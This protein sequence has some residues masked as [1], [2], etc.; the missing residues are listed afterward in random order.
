MTET[1]L[2]RKIHQ[3]YKLKDVCEEQR[4]EMRKTHPITMQEIMA[5]FLILG[6]GLMAACLIFCLEYSIYH[7]TRYCHLKHKT[8]HR[9]IR[10]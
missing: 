9:A 2:L 1:G 8:V 5:M 7:I 3:K 4:R 10:E 6:T